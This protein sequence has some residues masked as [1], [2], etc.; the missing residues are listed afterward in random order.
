MAE[1][2]PGGGTERDAEA[3]LLSRIR[4]GDKAACAECIELHAPAVYRLAVRLMGDETEA[5]DVVQETF[6][7]AFKAIDRFEGRSTLGTWLF[8]IAH[9]VALMRLRRAEPI[10]VPVDDPDWDDGAPE[11][12]QQLFDW[13][14]L[15]ERDFDTAE[16]QA[17]LEAA[18]RDLP[19]K[20][21]TVFILRELEG[22]STEETAEALD[23]S[24]EVVKTRLHRA[25]LR[26]RERLADYFTELAQTQ[27]EG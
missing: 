23:L 11:K 8:R 26:L 16:S 7:S 6:L 17:E 4:D 13:C 19:E 12:P 25:R 5:E 15:P 18:V 1:K 10:F 24:L 27:K 9:N 21:R 22:L 20:L 2:A 14:C 3:I